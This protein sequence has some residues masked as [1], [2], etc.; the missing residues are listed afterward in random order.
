MEYKTW[1]L[2]FII[3]HPINHPPPLKLQK[4]F[5]LDMRDKDIV[6]NKNQQQIGGGFANAFLCLMFSPPMPSIVSKFPAQFICFVPV[7]HTNY[8]QLE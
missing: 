2:I 6:C 8:S 5:A 3:Y 1:N 4:M 7:L